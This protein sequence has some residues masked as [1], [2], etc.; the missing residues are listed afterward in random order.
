M[1]LN[2]TLS[3]FRSLYESG[4]ASSTIATTKSALVK[5]FAYG[6]GLDLNDLCFS[7]ISRACAKQRPALR[8]DMLSWSLNKVLR[9][10]STISDDDCSY[11]HLFRK[12][13]FLV[14]L[15]SGARVSELAALSRDN[16]FIKF[17]ITGEVS[18]SPHPKFLAKNED[19]AHRWKLWILFH[20]PK[21][22][23]SAL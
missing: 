3:F 6:F 11:Q 18:L 12:T 19:P 5:V 4:L 23:L 21:T 17:L 16:G 20:C 14:A 15:A 10:A 8:P 13:L 2:T 9:L 1:S 22:P 7:S